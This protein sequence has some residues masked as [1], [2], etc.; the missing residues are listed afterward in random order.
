[1]A[2]IDATIAMARTLNTIIIDKKVGIV[3]STPLKKNFIPR[4]ARTKASPVPMYL[5]LNIVRAIRKYRAR[6]PSIA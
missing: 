1:L 6:N 4:K 2:K 3:M 5:N